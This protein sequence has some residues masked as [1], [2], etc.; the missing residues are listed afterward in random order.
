MV[1]RDTSVQLVAVVVAMTLSALS[2]QF[3][4]GTTGYPLLLGAASY[5]VVFAGSHIYLALRGDGDSVPV[6]ARWRFVALVV[7][8]VIG[9]VIGVSAGSVT[10]VGV[11]LST[12]VG[13]SVAL[14]FVGYWLYE[15]REGYRGS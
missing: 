12:V 14:L 9:M 6:S 13:L 3:G 8:A 7:V 10:V 1:P 5:V 15:A 11:R 2:I 4:G